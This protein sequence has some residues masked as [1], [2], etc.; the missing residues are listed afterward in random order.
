ML[1]ADESCSVFLCR[2]LTPWSKLCGACE[3]GL[4]CNALGLTLQI[5]SVRG[6][7]PISVVEK[8]YPVASGDLVRTPGELIPIEVEGTENVKKQWIQ[9]V[10]IKKGRD[11][12]NNTMTILNGKFMSS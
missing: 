4:L 8:L 1:K 12:W 7:L 6:T 3:K 11:Y 9:G 10:S 5:P 2:S